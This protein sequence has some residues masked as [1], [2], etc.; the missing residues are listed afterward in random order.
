VTLRRISFWGGVLCAI[1]FVMAYGGQGRLVSIET[2]PGPRD[3]GKR[4]AGKGKGP[5]TGQNSSKK[6]WAVK[7][8]QQ[9]MINNLVDQS[10]KLSAGFVSHS[11]QEAKVSVVSSATTSSSTSISEATSA[12]SNAVQTNGRQNNSN[13][14]KVPAL[15]SPQ[16]AEL[17]MMQETDQLEEYIRLK[18]EMHKI[19]PAITGIPTISDPDQYQTVIDHAMMLVRASKTRAQMP[20]LITLAPLPRDLWSLYVPEGLR[21]IRPG[22]VP[23]IM[24][25]FG[26][27]DEFECVESVEAVAIPVFH[28]QTAAIRPWRDNAEKARDNA[29]IFFQPFIL[30][31]Y[32]GGNIAYMAVDYNHEKLGDKAGSFFKP[33]PSL[34]N[35][36]RAAFFSRLTIISRS[37]LDYCFQPFIVSTYLFTELYSRR[38]ILT[39]HLSKATTVERLVRFAAEDSQTSAHIDLKL[40]TNTNALRST[41]SFLVAVI[42]QD[43]TT[44]LEDF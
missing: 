34:I 4:V 44:T 35:I 2:N 43:L 12:S 10:A 3:K 32:S 31:T 38:T 22:V 7:N 11:S 37:E 1:K 5:A 29:V 18:E 16:Q 40:H 23:A 21:T 15:V 30:I 14:S 27:W 26:A 9:S 8:N 25:Y 17:K 19:F 39:P 33:R 24:D 6:N 20:G 42:S 28:T 13:Q 36:N 41:I